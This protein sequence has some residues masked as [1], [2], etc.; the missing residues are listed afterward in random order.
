MGQKAEPS[1]AMVGADTAFFPARTPDLEAPPPAEATGGTAHPELAGYG[2]APVDTAR[3]E[4][5]PTT[6]AAE[7]PAR[8]GPPTEIPVA[9][10]APTQQHR[11]YAPPPEPEP[12]SAPAEETREMPPTGSTGSAPF[13]G[14]SDDP[15]RRPWPES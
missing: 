1:D 7:E 15:A 9:D 2:W 8:S 14:Q 10:D 3:T 11:L 6:E 13:G 12:P 4:T 5:L